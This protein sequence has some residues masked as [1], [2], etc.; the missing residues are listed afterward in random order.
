LDKGL[1][2]RSEDRYQ[3]ID[4][5]LADLKAV[6]ETVSEQADGRIQPD[7][8][9]W[10]L[11]L[12]RAGAIGLAG[13]VAALVAAWIYMAPPWVHPPIPTNAETPAQ[14][15]G[16]P[17]QEIAAPPRRPEVDDK[18]PATVASPPLS[19]RVADVPREEPVSL[20][21][22]P[23]VARVRPE[24]PVLQTPPPSLARV[25]PEEPVLQTPP[26]RA[27]PITSTESAREYVTM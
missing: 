25:P 24:E 1:A 26:P 14:F 27:P 19:P 16:Q 15:S 7:R 2:I 12:T 10:K 17:S 22:P 9:R 5:F 18:R 23:S 20:P 21:P 11:M 3:T 8:R 4:A 13:S 6:I